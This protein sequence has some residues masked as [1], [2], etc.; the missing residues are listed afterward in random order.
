[1]TQQPSI[2]I[3]K[4]PAQDSPL[5]MPDIGTGVDN[6][7][8]IVWRRRWLCMSV[9]V[10]VGLLGMVVLVA[11]PPRYTAHTIMAVMPRQPDL[12]A[13]DQ[14]T[15]V[16]P[17]RQPDIESEVQLMQSNDVLL[18][19]VGDVGLDSA[20]EIQRSSAESLQLATLH[21]LWNALIA[22]DWDN[23]WAR[24]LQPEAKGNESSHI[25]KSDEFVI[26][27]LRKSIKIEQIDKSATVDIAHIGKDPVQA[28]K[29]TNAIANAYIAARYAARRAEA[30]RA[31]TYLRRRSVDL[32]QELLAAEQAA[33]NFRVTTVLHDGRNIEQVRI[34]LEKVGA[35]LAAAKVA[36]I[37]AISKLQTVE[38]AVREGGITAAL[39]RSTPGMLTLDDRLREMSAQASAKADSM[40]DHGTD[41]PDS[42][43]ARKEANVL[44]REVVEEANARLRQLRSDVA[45]ADQQTHMLE[46][47]LQQSRSDFDR[48]SVALMTLKDLERQ[49]AAS[50]SFYE[51]F[52][53]RVKATE[54]VGF[55]E[56]ESWILSAAIPPVHP[57]SPKAIIILGA[58][59]VLA[60]GASLSLALL[61]EHKARQ[62][63]LSC[64]HLADKGLKALGVV[65][66]LGRR[67]RTLSGAAAASSRGPG[68]LFSESLG[69]IFTSVLELA[70]N[71]QSALVL[72][73]TSSLP[74]EGKS[75]TVIAL[76]AK[77]ASAGKRVL[78]IDGDLRAPQL[79]RAFGGR[80]SRGLAEIVNPRSA[81][82][83]LVYVDLESGIS[84]V[85]AGRSVE[86]PQN[87][88]RS[89]RLAEAVREWRKSYD[90][91]LID[92]PPVLPVADARILARLTDYC[93][94]VT[95]WRKTR[96]TVAMHALRLLRESGAQLAGI[97]VSKVDVK[98]LST[99]EFADSEMYHRAY[100]RY[101]PKTYGGG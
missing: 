74:F 42:Q 43:R 90:F 67:A 36:R 85:P 81:P 96:W 79:H 60:L 65:P 9:F 89:Q 16:N 99:Y 45:N 77:M 70:D 48:L 78:L 14:V 2:Y 38:A 31:A 86:E 56:A 47:T 13:A 26:E 51:A 7:R 30:E 11:L 3:P 88:L 68:S 23:L 12:A 84:V 29:I 95:H 39:Q 58:A 71:R 100:H 8:R 66:Y 73:V 41:H 33:E 63:I 49:A 20:N 52:L 87:V 19:V 17:A 55:N 72:L 28:A 5:E 40:V 93:L 76:A 24:L 97:V 1:M 53:A 92:S 59:L 94:F 32:R 44:R 82:Q 10:L 80:P 37:A 18:Q 21:K 46:A 62:T 4:L 64:Q 34:E 15:A 91:I 6:L 57:S 83:D 25:G 35:E 27:A 50:R 101:L 98:E 69:S 75:T 61:A 22:G 54:Q